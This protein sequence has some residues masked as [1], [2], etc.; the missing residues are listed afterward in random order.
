MNNSQYLEKSSACDDVTEASTC[1]SDTVDMTSE[2]VDSDYDTMLD[3]DSVLYEIL[4]AGTTYYKCKK[5]STTTKHLSKIWKISQ[6]TPQQPIDNNNQRC[7]RKS[8][9]I[10]K[11]N[12][13]TDHRMLRCKG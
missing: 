12:Y 2:S 4:I 7:V 13:S 8:D 10:M 6:E 5:N 1:V 3:Y 11:R 9:P